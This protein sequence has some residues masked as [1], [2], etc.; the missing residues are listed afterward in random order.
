MALPEFWMSVRTATRLLAGPVV[1]D[2]PRLDTESIEHTL[3]GTT[4]WLTPDAVAG[5]EDADFDFLDQAE[6]VRLAKLV[7]D[8]QAVAS[9]VSPKAPPPDE[10]VSQALPLFRDIVQALEFDRYGDVEAYRLGKK[11]EQQLKPDWPDE[12]A[13]LRFRTGRDH[14]GDPGIWILGL[15]KD[16]AAPSDDQFLAAARTLRPLIQSAARKIVPDRW[17]YLHFRSVGEQAELVE[18][19]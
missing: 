3:R 1:A 6:R 12:L 11:I 17:P 10:A 2:A 5:F 16:D 15:V 18:S 4:L 14:T 19:S 9:A 13:E 8:F 7:A